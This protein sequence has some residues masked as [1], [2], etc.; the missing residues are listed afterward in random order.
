[1]YV[2]ASETPRVSSTC[3]VLRQTAGY[4]HTQQ[5]LLRII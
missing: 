5:A 2:F 1:M 4:Q 3:A